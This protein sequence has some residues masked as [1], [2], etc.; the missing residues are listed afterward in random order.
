MSNYIDLQFWKEIKSGDLLTYFT[1]VVAYI[2]Y[3]WSVKRDFDSWK[4]LFSSFEADLESQKKW[5]GGEYFS[6]TYEDKD[7]FNPYKIIYPLSFES[8]PEIIRR[9]VAELPWVS[10]EFIK[11]LSL[12]NERIIA[13]NSLLDHI[14]KV[15]SADPVMSEKLKDKLNELGLGNDN[16]EFNEFKKSI[17]KRVRRMNNEKWF[18]NCRNNKKNDEVLYLAESIRRLHRIV[19]VKLIGNKSEQDKLHYLYSEIK[20]ELKNILSNFD[21]KRPFL[22]K[23]AKYVFVFSLLLF[24]LIEIFF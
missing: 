22:I 2:A 23:Y 15:S 18:C 3:T 1:L 11:Q 10:K 16:I 6:K 21:R 17:H 14:K 5:L 7:S 12:F 8:L 13:F 24:F 4:S 20:N 9:G 19:H